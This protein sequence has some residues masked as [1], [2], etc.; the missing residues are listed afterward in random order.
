MGIRHQRYSSGSCP[1]IAGHSVHPARRSYTH[2]CW[3][4]DQRKP[5]HLCALGLPCWGQQGW[6]FLLQPDQCGLYSSCPHLS[7][8]IAADVLLHPKQT[9]GASNLSAKPLFYKVFPQRTCFPHSWTYTGYRAWLLFAPLHWM[10]RCWN[11]VPPPCCCLGDVAEISS[12]RKGGWQTQ[13]LGTSTGVF[14]AEKDRT[15]A[16]K[17]LQTLKPLIGTFHL[18]IFISGKKLDE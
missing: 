9:N 12:D 14:G 16:G 7:H 11:S 18:Q 1:S 6:P 13:F 8:S 2:V 15:G 4:W 17:P 3:S 5:C 10:G